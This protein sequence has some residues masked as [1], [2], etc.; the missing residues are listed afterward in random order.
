MPPATV[1]GS[2][3]RVKRG[4]LLIHPRQ[5]FLRRIDRAGDAA[6]GR[7][8]G[9]AKR[10]QQIVQ[11]HHRPAGGN[12]H[13][14]S[15][16]VHFPA[17]ARPD[18]HDVFL[19]GIDEDVANVLQA[20]EILDRIG[21]GFVVRGALVQGGFQAGEAKSFAS[22]RRRFRSPG[23]FS[24]DCRRSLLSTPRSSVRA[25][26]N[27]PSVSIETPPTDR[28]FVSTT[29]GRRGLAIPDGDHDHPNNGDR[30]TFGTTLADTRDGKRAWECLS[31]TVPDWRKSLTGIFH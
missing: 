12:A 25:L 18:Q 6:V 31:V 9:R 17:F 27:T 11:Q 21:D 28:V 23:I 15:L 20:G 10:H 1:C 29:V 22:R 5:T 19:L 26:L 30:Q 7:G 13:H 3:L 8:T 14:A 4:Q 16:G 24:S 2:P